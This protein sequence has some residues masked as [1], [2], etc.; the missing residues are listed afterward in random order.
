MHT[1]TWPVNTHFTYNLN[2]VHTLTLDPYLQMT[3]FTRCVPF[4]FNHLYIVFCRHEDGGESVYIQN[5]MKE[6]IMKM[7]LTFELRLD[8]DKSGVQNGH[9]GCPG[10][11]SWSCVVGKYLIGSGKR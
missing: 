3:I 2:N 10:R 1:T 9:R 4:P 6:E 7:S 8:F 5:T 11:G